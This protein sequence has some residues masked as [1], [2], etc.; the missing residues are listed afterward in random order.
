MSTV[1]VV[2]LF[3][4]ERAALHT[5]HRLDEGFQMIRDYQHQGLGLQR[6]RI[7]EHGG[8]LIAPGPGAIDQNR[9]FNIASRG[10]NTPKSTLFF[11]RY[12]QIVFDKANAQ[13][14][15]FLFKGLDSLKGIGV[16][17]VP[18]P[19]VERYQG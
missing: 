18:G 3:E 4:R 9:R 13:G 19:G 15:G 12:E 14:K 5:D 16:I 17:K 7:A 2:K 10:F 11:Q 1:P 8:D 6:Y